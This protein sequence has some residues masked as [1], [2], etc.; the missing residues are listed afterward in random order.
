MSKKGASSTPHIDRYAHVPR[1]VHVLND[2]PLHTTSE[3]CSELP[4]VPERNFLVRPLAE[5]EDLAQALKSLGAGI[6]KIFEY[7]G[8]LALPLV[9]IKFM[10]GASHET[11]A[12]ILRKLRDQT[13]T[14]RR[15]VELKTRAVYVVHEA[16]L[17]SR[18]LISLSIAA[19]IQSDLNPL[20][21]ESSFIQDIHA[22]HSKLHGDVHSVRIALAHDEE[23]A[24]KVAAITRAYGLQ[25][26]AII[27][28]P[29]IVCT[30]PS[31]AC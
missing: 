22:K 30:S 21:V 16:G 27:L 4:V 7:E 25:D 1:A 15:S 24:N 19:P 8:N 5:T 3:E 23:T 9:P 2:E 14:A 12:E 6:I 26:T 17:P 29:P 28:K 18:K 13:E 11:V 20:H 31:R 10:D